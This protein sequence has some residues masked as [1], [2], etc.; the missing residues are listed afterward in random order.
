MIEW[1]TTMGGACLFAWVSYRYGY[2]KGR[3]D[4]YRE[5]LNRTITVVEPQKN[6]TVSQ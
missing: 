3:F 2:A 6:E 4:E 1:L 5:T